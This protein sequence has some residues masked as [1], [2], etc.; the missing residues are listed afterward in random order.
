VSPRRD[1]GKRSAYLGQFPDDMANTIA[2]EL[3]AAGILW[4]YKQ[5]IWI[6][7]ILFLG[8]W[9][10]RMFVDAERLD[11]AKEIVERVR[12]MERTDG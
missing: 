2:G 3:E 4:S 12:S 8:E 9:G 1:K 5:A 11:D 7:Q 10:T 6:T